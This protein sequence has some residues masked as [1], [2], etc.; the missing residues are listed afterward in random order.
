MTTKINLGTHL[1]LRAINADND[2]RALERVRSRMSN[3]EVSKLTY[4]LIKNNNIIA[5]WAENNSKHNK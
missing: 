5:P 1:L 2:I 3:S 4:A